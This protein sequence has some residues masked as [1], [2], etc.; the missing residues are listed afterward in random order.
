MTN[1]KMRAGVGGVFIIE[2]YDRFGNF[3][4][5]EKTHNIVTNQGLDFL[6]NVLLHRSTQIDP[7]YC[8]LVETNTTATSAMTYA[9]PVYTE[10]TAYSE[11]TRP[12]YA[13]AAASSQSITNSA[14]KAAFTMN[15]TKT[16]YGA[17]LVGGGTDPTVKGNILGGG[18][19]LCYAK[20]GASRVA[21]S[22]DIVYLT[23][24]FSAAD[25]GL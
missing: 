14:S 22:A 20:F 6:L 11:V 1:I 18:T 19:L 23:Y 21:E 7:W 24:T 3:K 2:C 15:A 12:E 8:V 25:N 17:S 10:T 13:E 4:W 9:A 16:L 5:I